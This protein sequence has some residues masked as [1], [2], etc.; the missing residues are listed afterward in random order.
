M[1][2]RRRN[3][4][5]FALVDARGGVLAFV[6]PAKGVDLKP[7]VGQNI[8]VTGIRGYMAEYRTPHVTV[9]RVAVL[10]DFSRETRRR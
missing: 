6:T 2:S 1:I 9:E 10:G 4:P 7:R 3:A 8:G 5:P